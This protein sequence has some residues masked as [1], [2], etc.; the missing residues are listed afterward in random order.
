MV[1][2]SIAKLLILSSF[3]EKMAQM[4]VGLVSPGI[5]STWLSNLVNDHITED[6]FNRWLEK[7]RNSLSKI[8]SKNRWALLPNNLGVRTH[9]GNDKDYN[10]IY[11]YVTKNSSPPDKLIVS[12]EMILQSQGKIP[13]LW[14]WIGQADYTDTSK[15]LEADLAHNEFLV[16]AVKYL[17]GYVD[18]NSVKELIQQ[19]RKVIDG[20]RSFFVGRPQFLGEGADGVVYAISPNAILKFFNDEHLYNETKKAID[21]LHTQPDLA[22]TEAMIYDVGKLTT[23]NSENPYNIQYYIMERMKPITSFDDVNFTYAIK[24]IIISV[25]NY[26]ISSRFS[27]WKEFKSKINDPKVHSLIKSEVMKAAQLL[28]P[29]IRNSHHKYIYLIESKNIQ[30]ND[31]WLEVLIEEIIMKYL[32][33]RTDLHTGNLGVTN[34]GEFRYFDPAY[35]EYTSEFNDRI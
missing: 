29:D 30:L 21:R 1:K 9:V 33:S 7:N 26:I 25:I 32:T 20:I 23:N 28:A 14:L 8:P 18:F 5:D 35:R 11:V 12:E 19:N 3:F 4:A 31:N 24:S 17:Y 6:D 13:P 2:R 22:K 10:D 34:H 15:I 27:K 16:N